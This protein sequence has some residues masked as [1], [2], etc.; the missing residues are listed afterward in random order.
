MNVCLA[1]WLTEVDNNQFVKTSVTTVKKFQ[2]YGTRIFLCSM[3]QGQNIFS[4]PIL[5]MK[6]L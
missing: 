4:C 2:Q 6:M 1:V 3:K 5:N